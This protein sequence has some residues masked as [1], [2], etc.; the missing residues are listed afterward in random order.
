MKTILAFIGGCTL[1]YGFGRLVA[2][3]T[4]MKTVEELRGAKEPVQG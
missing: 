4:R 2:L 1:L 3:Y